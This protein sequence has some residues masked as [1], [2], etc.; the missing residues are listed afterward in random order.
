MTTYATRLTVRIGDINYGGHLGHDNLVT[1]LHQARLNFL[2]HLGASELDCFGA[3]LIMRKLT[4]DYL[5]EAFLGDELEVIMSLSAIKPSRFTL[6]YAV[7][8]PQ[9]GTTIATASTMMVAFD[10]HT[11]RV[12]ALS[13]QFH[14]AIAEYCHG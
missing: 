4:V 7:T 12:Q 5:G 8:R 3:G 14:Q 9:D 2:H 1:L 10:Y 11:H 6:E 13:D